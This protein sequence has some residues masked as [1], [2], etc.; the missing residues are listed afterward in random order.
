[1]EEGEGVF[2]PVCVKGWLSHAVPTAAIAPD[3]ASIT[4]KR[5]EVVVSRCTATG[6]LKAALVPKPA[7]VE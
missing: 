1:M 6:Y 7:T 4:R 2:E 3:P 5:P